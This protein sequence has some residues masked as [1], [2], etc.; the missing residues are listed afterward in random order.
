MKNWKLSISDGVITIENNNTRYIGTGDIAVLEDNSKLTLEITEFCSD[1]SL[2]RWTCSGK[3]IVLKHTAMESSDGALEIS[4]EL[5]NNSRQ[6]LKPGDIQVLGM[7]KVSADCEFDRAFVSSQTILGPEGIVYNDKSVHSSSFIGFTEKQGNASALIGFTNLSDAFYKCYGDY[8]NGTWNITAACERENVPVNSQ[9]TLKIANLSL[10]AG[11]SLSKHLD[12]YGS[13]LADNMAGKKPDEIKTGWCSWYYYYGQETQEDIIKNVKMLA[14]SP[15]KDKIKVIQLDDGWNLPHNGHPRVWGDWEAGSKFPNG[16]KYIV[17]VIHE[18]GFEAGLWLA[19]FSVSKDSKLFN[20]HPEW[21]IGMDKDS[22]LYMDD[23]GLDL[24]HPEALDYLR[25]VFNRVFCEWGFDYIKIDFLLHAA[26][27]GVRYDSTKT[28]TEAFRQGLSL[29]KEIAGDKFVLGCGAPIYPSIGIVDGMRIGAD[30]G[31]RW[32]LPINPGAWPK[33]NC[34]LKPAFYN[35]LY[36]QWMHGKLWQNDP[37]CIMVRD[38]ESP[39][40]GNMFGKEFIG[41]VMTKE[42]Y[43]IKDEEAAAWM[44]GLWF[45]G[46]MLL[47]SEVW[48]ELPEERKELVKWCFPVNDKPV[49]LVDYYE[50]D[51][52]VVMKSESGPKMIGIFNLSDKEKELA[53][54][55]SMISVTKWSFKEKFSVETFSGE[56]DRICFPVIKPRSSRVWIIE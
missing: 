46:G 4:T 40:E 14:A 49:A 56:G 32:D 35:T 37:D 13:K 19:P 26:N 6:V 7:I 22:I 31:N 43:E 45:T 54:P 50:D 39:F 52:F 42:D 34:A 8:H 3:D 10:Y 48:D 11:K 21:L 1:A 53:L 28:S 12:L 44:R 25:E 18:Y 16:M 36:R 17:D 41:H 15:L 20:E 51:E 5:I 29:I 24:T 33:G 2:V 47:L 9:S 38:Y 23:Y 55:S 30:V 27:K